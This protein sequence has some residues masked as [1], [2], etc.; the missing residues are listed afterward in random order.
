[1]FHLD[2]TLVINRGAMRTDETISRICEA[3]MQISNYC[4]NEAVAQ[5][6]GARIRRARIDYPLSQEELAIRAGVTKRTIAN[7]EHGAD[8]TLSTL[9]S[10]LRALDML[11]RMDMLVEPDEP[12]P[13][14]LLAQQRRPERKRVSRKATSDARWKWGDER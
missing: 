14:E 11:S 12:R 6:L 1:M 3:D 7:I 2:D 5:E 9:A 10:V 13:S 4:S 8:T